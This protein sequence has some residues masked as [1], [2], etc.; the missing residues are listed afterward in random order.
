MQNVRKIVSVVDTFS[1]DNLSIKEKVF[2]AKEIALKNINEVFNNDD[3]F[4]LLAIN[5]IVIHEN[6]C[7]ND[8]DDVYYGVKDF[9]NK[10]VYFDILVPN[11][12][13][14]KKIFKDEPIDK[15]IETFF[16][17]YSEAIAEIKFQTDCKF[18]KQIKSIL[19]EVLYKEVIKIENDSEKLEALAIF[20]NNLDLKQR[21][22]W[23]ERF[24]NNFISKEYLLISIDGNTP[25]Y[26]G[27]EC[28][29]FFDE[30]NEIFIVKDLVNKI[31][32]PIVDLYKR[33]KIWVCQIANKDK[34]VHIRLFDIF[35][36]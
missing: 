33:G 24:M 20:S 2:N 1:L 31:D 22:T 21:K 3:I 32:Y 34:E 27:N 25:I 18:R 26:K 14:Y 23:F 4:D 13:E 17:I 6:I 7:K 35:E 19:G 12:D 5:T 11:I 36:V 8:Y 10:A 15:I 28:G 9:K 16:N 30:E 29:Y